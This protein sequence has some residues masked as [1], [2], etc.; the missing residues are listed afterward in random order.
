[1]GSFFT[2]YIHPKWGLMLYSVFSL[3]M[4]IASYKLVEQKEKLNEG[5]IAHIKK[6]LK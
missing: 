4:A 6:T 3:T 5:K 1:M 2:E